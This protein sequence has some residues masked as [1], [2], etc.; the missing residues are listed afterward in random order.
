MPTRAT[1]SWTATPQ[2]APRTVLR[3][4]RQ[5]KARLWAMVRSTLGPGSRISALEA[6][7]KAR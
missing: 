6:T 5:P 4:R 7:T 1:E 2:V 3:A